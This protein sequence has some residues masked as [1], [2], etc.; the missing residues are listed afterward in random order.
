M[1]SWTAL[2]NFEISSNQ[3]IGTIPT[4][5]AN[6][7][8]LAFLD[9]GNNRLTGAIPDTLGNLGNLRKFG[10]FFRCLDF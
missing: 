10:Y 8:N 9:L 2:E 1:G 5:I 4:S 7:R 3:I 6:M